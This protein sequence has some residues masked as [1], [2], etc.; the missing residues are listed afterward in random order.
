MDL[1]NLEKKVNI[2]FKN[3]DLLKQAFIHRSYIKS[4]TEI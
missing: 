3:K 2:I 1:N 4:L